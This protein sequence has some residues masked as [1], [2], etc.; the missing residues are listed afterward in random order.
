MNTIVLSADALVSDDMLYMKTL[1]AFQQYLAQ[2]ACVQSIRS[3]YPT[4]TYPCHTTIAT[5]LYPDRHGVVCNLVSP[6]E[7]T[8][9]PIPWLWDHSAVK[10][11]D[12]FDAAKRAGLTTAAVF[13]PVTGRHPSVDYLIDEYWTQSP[14]D[15][16][17]EA[18]ARM[19]SSPDMIRII[20][21]NKHLLV[22]RKHPMADQFV[23]ACAC[24]IIR[25]YKPDLIMIHPANIDGYRHSYGVFHDRV[26]EGIRETD[27]WIGEL[28]HAAQEAGIAED[29]NFILTSDHGQMNIQRV[30]NTNVFLADAGWIRSETDW[31]VWAQSGGMCSFVYL[32]DPADE[33]LHMEVHRRLSAMAQEGIYGFSRVYTREEADAEEHLSGSFSFVL[34][35][36]GFSAFGDRYQRPAVSPINRSDYRSGAAT[37]GYLPNK[38][39]QPVFYCK[40]PSFAAD[41][42]LP[43]ARLV[44]EAP[45]IAAA[46]GIRLPDTDGRILTEL[47]AVR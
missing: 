2:G 29:T 27:E 43:A 3:I 46:L 13:W 18:F 22:E 39:P 33:Q 17:E 25:E 41:V 1:P 44:D 36:D 16:V 30:V 20:R 21:K 35:T 28:M 5:G 34:E 4:I 12:I 14:E 40:G 15:T 6:Y 38:G 7:T 10:A 45:T 26:T 42:Q 23:I 9:Q 32:K 19:G 11:P 8:A 47:L 37:H 24:D 31:D